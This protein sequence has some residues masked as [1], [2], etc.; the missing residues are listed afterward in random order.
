MAAAHALETDCR[1]EPFRT[2]RLLC[3]DDGPRTAGRGG[4]A[5]SVG[6]SPAPAPS[7]PP[8]ARAPPGWARDNSVCTS[9]YTV[10]SFVPRSLF[11]QFRRVANQY[12]LFISFLM[13]F[14]SYS[15]LWYSPLQAYR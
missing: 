15:G 7:P 2:L 6:T 13:V 3:R 10:L 1:G 9:K 5:A 8:P 14:G 4:T 12:F 11:E